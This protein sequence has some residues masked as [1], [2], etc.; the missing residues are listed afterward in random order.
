MK[1]FENLSKQELIDKLN[2]HNKK[3][4]LFNLIQ[5]NVSYPFAI[6]DASSLIFNYSNPQYSSLTNVAPDKIIG[7]HIQD[8]IG[9]DNFN[10]AKPFIMKAISGQNTEHENELEFANGLKWQKVTYTPLKD[11]N[12]SVKNIVINSFDIEFPQKKQPAHIDSE[13]KYKELIDRLPDAVV[14]HSNGVIKYFNAAVVKM[15]GIDEN[16]II[17]NTIDKVL[18]IDK[19][20]NYFINSQGQTAV[21]S[22]QVPYVGKINFSSVNSIDAEIYTEQCIFE[23]EAAVQLMIRDITLRNV[24]FRKEKEF[25]QHLNKEVE[26][27]T[28]NLNLQAQKLKDSQIALTFLLED[29]NETRKALLHSNTELETVNSDLESFAYSVSHDLRAP[30]RHIDGFAQILQNKIPNKPDEILQYFNKI[31]NA[32]S[33]MHN[34]INDLLTFSRLGRKKL[35]KT[36]IELNDLFVQLIKDAEPD[37][38][39]RKI[40]WVIDTFPIIYGDVEMLKIAFEN[41]LS[42]AIKF[43]SKNDK[44]KISILLEKDKLSPKNITIAVV[45]NGVGFDMQYAHKIFGVF[46]RLHSADEFAGTGIGMAIV[47]KI[48]QSHKGSVTAYGEIDKG[49]RFTITLPH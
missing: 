43:T 9:A 31:H 25:Y 37:I 19:N 17:G 20:E 22:N 23:G 10:F 5:S 41:L 24:A 16:K 29:V 21:G 34:L 48:I 28:H 18:N 32:S 35:K 8:V 45:D 4:E 6:L 30:L 39:D 47:K 14:I 49:A 11:K 38:K 15:T 26:K 40:K 33:K 27:Q 1:D 13:K 36:P 44:A 7:K 42:N 2:E 12:N 3:L 46:E